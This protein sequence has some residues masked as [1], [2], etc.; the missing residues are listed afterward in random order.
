MKRVQT[1]LDT[2]YGK[3]GLEL[4]WSWF[5]IEYQE[6]GTA[7]AHGCFRLKCN[8]GISDL[9][10]KVLKG[11]I[12]EKRLVELGYDAGLNQVN[13]YDTTDTWIEPEEKVTPEPLTELQRN[14]LFEDAWIGKYATAIICQFRDEYLSTCHPRPPPDSNDNVRS[15]DTNFVQAW[16]K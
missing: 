9:A 12:A 11:R 7:H 5:L 3:H 15:D 1:L 16:V 14:E 13:I 6:W 4:E 2:Y 10:Q 8:P